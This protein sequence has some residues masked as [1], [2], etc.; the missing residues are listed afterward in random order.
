MDAERKRL[1]MA[2]LWARRAGREALRRFGDTSAR[3]KSDRSVVTEADRC[4]E[5]MIVAEIE[6][7]FPR[8]RIL[9][10]EYGTQGGEGAVRWF[11]DPIDGT[12][13][14]ATQLHVWCV[15][16][17]VYRHR[18]LRAGVLWVPFTREEYYAGTDG[19][20]H[21]NGGMLRRPQPGE[22]DSETLLC[23]PS[24][25]HRAYRI[26][27]PGKC[28]SLGSTAY[29][30]AMVLEGRAAGALIG[31]PHIWDIGAVW[32]MGNSLGMKLRSLGGAEGCEK[33]LL[34]GERP[35]SPLLFGVP[36]VLDRL[37]ERIQRR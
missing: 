15:S 3:R 23:V 26:D 6:H 21:K 5:R 34:S 32:G 10:E 20:V 4:I 29:H 1:T 35:G 27:F 31:R 37:T 13:A 19:E 33:A 24:N 11:I 36:E 16:L 28:R 14:Y 17:A 7:H 12:A 9:G 30:M 22:W 18:S 2:R 8:D 25:A